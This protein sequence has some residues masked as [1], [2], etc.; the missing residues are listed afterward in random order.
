MMNSQIRSNLIVDGLIKT[1][2]SGKMRKAT[3]TIGIIKR[4]IKTIRR[5]VRKMVWT[6][7]RMLKRI[8]RKIRSGTVKAKRTIR[9]GTAKAKRMI[10]KN[11]IDHHLN[12]LFM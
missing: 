7:G 3:K 12:L 5:I 10:R 1:P 6:L 9:S 8:A 2:R 11:H 4:R